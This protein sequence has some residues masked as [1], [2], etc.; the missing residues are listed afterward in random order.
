MFFDI[1]I[2][3]G[4]VSFTAYILSQFVYHEKVVVIMYPK[5]VSRIF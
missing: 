4:Y 2:L 5:N 3:K 1:V